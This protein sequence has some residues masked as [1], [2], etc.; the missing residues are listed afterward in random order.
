MRGFA[1]PMNAFVPAPSASSPSLPRQRV[2]FKL[3]AGAPGDVLERE[4]DAA[5]DA[6]MQGAAIARAPTAAAP[7]VQ[8]MC[9][10]CSEEE[11]ALQRS[12]D[13]AAASGAAAFAGAGALPPSLESTLTRARAGAAV[14]LPADTRAFMEAGLGHDFSRV[15]IHATGEASQSAQAL[16]ARAFTV[17]SDIV[18][19]RGEYAPHT[20]AGQ[21]LLAHELTHVVQ[22]SG[23]GGAAGVGARV[24]RIPQT[25]TDRAV[26]DVVAQ[27]TLPSG[28]PNAKPC[29]APSYCPAAF[30]Q[31]YSS[32]AYARYR[33]NMDSPLLL[34][35]IR[36]AVDSRVIPLW[37]DYLHG[38]SPP[39]DL[40]STFG[41]DFARSPTTLVTAAYLTDELRRALTATPPAFAPGSTT[42]MVDIAPMIPAAVKAIDDPASPRCMNFN[43]PSDIAGN[44]AGGVGKDQLTYKV[45][46]MPSPFNDERLVKGFATV[47]R[48]A[49]G[50]MTV[51]PTYRFTVRDTVDLCPGDCGSPLE[52]TA[53]VPFS[54]WEATGIAGDVPFW[55]DFDVTGTPF[56]IAGKGPPSPPPPG[57]PPTGS[58]KAPPPVPTSTKA[59]SGPPPPVPKKSP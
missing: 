11:E 56:I 6:V 38:G 13:G 53:T 1:S 54:E 49:S 2:Q 24:Q 46:A 17:G 34:L 47:W 37:V 18:F 55:I 51:F 25:A 31:P 42:A 58:S 21:R 52:Q 4:A 48:A 10:T 29:P 35:G 19:A 8:R 22:Q 12:S 44:I 39:R 5:A 3:T 14:P 16:A 20:R 30:C 40:T 28:A 50:D 41:A 23:G 32:E 36:A 7:A 57:P 59:P 45:G 9:S 43:V 26:N 15:R 27:K 33:L